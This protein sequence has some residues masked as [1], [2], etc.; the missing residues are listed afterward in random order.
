ML[1]VTNAAKII[2]VGVVNRNARL[3]F[4]R[5]RDGYHMYKV[6]WLTTKRL[7]PCGMALPL[8]MIERWTAHQHFYTA[9]AR[10]CIY[11]NV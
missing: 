4:Y 8:V 7:Q 1:D 2:N 5:D 10:R 3:K 6:R 11:V 9:K